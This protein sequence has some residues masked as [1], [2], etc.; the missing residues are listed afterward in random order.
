[1]LIALLSVNYFRYSLKCENLN[2]TK[3]MKQNTDEFFLNPDIG[4]FSST[5]QS[6]CGALT[7]KDVK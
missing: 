1:V 4:N 6:D 7:F 2:V 5:V 3:L